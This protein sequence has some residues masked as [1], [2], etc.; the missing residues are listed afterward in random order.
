MRTEQQQAARIRC[1]QKI[2]VVKLS[3]VFFL[4]FLVIKWKSIGWYNR[5][6]V[7]HL[8]TAA[9]A[10][11]TSSEALQAPFIAVFLSIVLSYVLAITFAA[12][13]PFLRI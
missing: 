12:M 4:T 1:L 6:S 3:I 5:V 9:I 11:V 13:I 2:D 10:V 7:V 8:S